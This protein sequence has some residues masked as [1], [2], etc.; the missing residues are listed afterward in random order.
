MIRFF[1]LAD[2]GYLYTYR[3]RINDCMR[4]FL[5]FSGHSSA[6]ITWF[7]VTRCCK[8]WCHPC[9]GAPT[10][11]NVICAA[12]ITY[13]SVRWSRSYNLVPFWSHL[14]L[15][16]SVLWAC[17]ISYIANFKKFSFTSFSR[18]AQ[19]CHWTCMVSFT[20][21]NPVFHMLPKVLVCNSVL[22][23]KHI[24]TRHSKKTNTSQKILFTKFTAVLLALSPQTHLIL[25]P[26][27][28]SEKTPLPSLPHKHHSKF[29]PFIREISMPNY[30]THTHTILLGES[31]VSLVLSWLLKRCRQMTQTLQACPFWSQQLEP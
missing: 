7:G 16:W 8:K 9:I 3:V 1:K 25:T 23:Q 6:G 22:V 4:F 28:T 15:K 20:R 19:F 31:R 17:N 5:P 21:H 30:S 2:L 11:E 14:S 18:C 13:H 12:H 10:N 29:P 26:T 24:N 27:S